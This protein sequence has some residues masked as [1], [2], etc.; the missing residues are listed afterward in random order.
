MIVDDHEVVADALRMSLQLNGVENVVVAHDLSSEGVLTLMIDFA[1]DVALV[2]YHLADDETSVDLIRELSRADVVVI[3]LTGDPRPA[4]LAEGLEAG[5]IGYFVKSGSLDSLVMS[6]LNA[7]SGQTMLR[8]ASRETLMKVLET[9]RASERRRMAPFDELTPR[10][11]DVLRALVDGHS[12][13]A[14]ARTHDVSLTTIRSQI[15]A[16]L[17]KLEVTSQIGAVALARQAAW[18]PD[19]IGSDHDDAP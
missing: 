16:V 10:E 3:L 15:G 11:Q 4:L 12:A 14:V 5:A 13:D 8:P 19:G 1:P 7:G 17:R 18:P 9:T 6:V 2:D